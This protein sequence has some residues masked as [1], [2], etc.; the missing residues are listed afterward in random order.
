MADFKFHCPGCGQ[1]MQATDDMIGDSIE[2]PICRKVLCVPAP[3]AAGAPGA[4]VPC[5]FCKGLIPRDSVYCDL[6]GQRQSPAPKAAAAP[7]AGKPRLGP[8]AFIL[9]LAVLVVVT[10]AVAY[11]TQSRRPPAAT[12]ADAAVMEPPPAVVAVTAMPAETES[13]AE[14]FAVTVVSA[15]PPAPPA[16][17]EPPPPAPPPAPPPET[18][19]YA[20]PPPAPPAPPAPADTAAAPENA[21]SAADEIMGIFERTREKYK[22]V[23]G[24]IQR[25]YQARV[26][27][28]QTNFLGGLETLEHGMQSKGDLM[29]ILAVRKEKEAFQQISES[30]PVIRAT[31]S[32]YPEVAALKKNYN[33]QLEGLQQ[34]RDQEIVL[35]TGQYDKR[36]AEFERR[37]TQDGKIDQALLVHEERERVRAQRGR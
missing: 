9:P 36:L 16:A 5:A 34:D 12:E 15:P 30:P 11:I 20:A 21:A 27:Q 10:L 3:N 25:A 26:I 22:E 35:R 14:D 19:A 8:L 32:P 24:E 37:L 18:A 7:A 29:G 6:C 4:D 31:D 2:C 23:L 13:T 17:I 28:V 33:Q 1:K